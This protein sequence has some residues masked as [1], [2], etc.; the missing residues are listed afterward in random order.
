MSKDRMDIWLEGERELFV[1]MQNFA[2]F[3]R[4]GS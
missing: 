1:N 3:Q 4:Q 2:L